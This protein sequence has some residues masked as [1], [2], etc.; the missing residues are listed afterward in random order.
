[1][2]ILDW[3]LRR[4]KKADEKADKTDYID[5][6]KVLVKCKRCDSL[7]LHLGAGIYLFREPDALCHKRGTDCDFHS[8]P[9]SSVLEAM[10]GERKMLEAIQK[11]ILGSS[12]SPE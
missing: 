5:F 6:S 7:G 1:M 9:H 2:G 4:T 12:G 8:C 3:L 11:M 10:G